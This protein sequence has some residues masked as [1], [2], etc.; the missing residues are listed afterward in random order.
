MSSNGCQFGDSTF[1]SRSHIPVARR[2]AYSSAEAE[3][4]AMSERYEPGVTDEDVQ[5]HA[6]HGENDNLSGRS[7]AEADALQGEWQPDEKHSSDKKR[8]TSREH[9]AGLLKSLDAFAE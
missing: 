8:R 4:C 5:R 2:L 1:Q 3:P 9:D 7:N 6:R